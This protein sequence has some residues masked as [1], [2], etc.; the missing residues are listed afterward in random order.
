MITK[1]RIQETGIRASNKCWHIY[2]DYVEKDGSG[3][4]MWIAQTKTRELARLI[5]KFLNSTT[6]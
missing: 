4:S 1:Y 6:F 5:A 2:E 3:T